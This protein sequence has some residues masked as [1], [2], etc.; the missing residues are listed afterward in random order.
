MN[1]ND[2]IKVMEY[3]T[4]A[5]DRESIVEWL[6]QAQTLKQDIHDLKIANNDL[7][8]KL[9]S[10]EKTISHLNNRV[11]ILQGKIGLVNR[12][13]CKKCKQAFTTLEIRIKEDK[14]GK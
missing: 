11:N 12:V 5:R 1:L 4:D 8:N 6:K 7:K 13:A 10:K 2:A 3:I 9:T 14:Y